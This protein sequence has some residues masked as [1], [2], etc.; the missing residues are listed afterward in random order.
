MVCFSIKI[1]FHIYDNFSGILVMVV[2]FDR[3][4]DLAEV[5][6]ISVAQ[7]SCFII[8]SYRYDP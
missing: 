8:I 4:L 7:F 2:V 3:S 5:T 1:I 6:L